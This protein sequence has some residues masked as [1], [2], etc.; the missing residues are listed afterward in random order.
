TPGQYNVPASTAL[1]TAKSRLYFSSTNNQ[2]HQL[3][4][5]PATL[6]NLPRL[7]SDVRFTDQAGQPVTRLARGQLV[8]FSGQVLD[9][10]QGT[11]VPLEGVASVLIEDSAP[12]NVTPPSVSDSRPYAY[13]FSARP[14]Y[15]G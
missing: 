5:D 3:M 12:T 9:R 14:M 1:L 13:R 2:K 15:H 6:L 7:W 10:P 11:P 8:S 4:G